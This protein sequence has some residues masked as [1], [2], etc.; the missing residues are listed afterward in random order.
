MHRKSRKVSHR[1][2][3]V[4]S[5]NSRFACPVQCNT[6]S[7]QKNTR[8]LRAKRRS[9]LPLH[10]RPV[11]IIC[12][13]RCAYRAFTAGLQSPLPLL[14][15]L[16]FVHKVEKPAACPE[17]S[18]E[19]TPGRAWLLTRMSRTTTH[20]LPQ[21]RQPALFYCETSR[22]PRPLRASHVLGFSTLSTFTCSLHPPLS[23]SR[24]WLVFFAFFCRG[25]PFLF[26]LTFSYFLPICPSATYT[27]IYFSPV[28]DKPHLM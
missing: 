3:I 12:S 23:F 1:N 4:E 7:E 13:I 10:R 9:A 11:S 16:I 27:R 8:P 5:P 28:G 25:L 17:A 18:P 6:V 22:L 24:P 21:A 14:C 26:L 20:P 19:R 15:F 2:V